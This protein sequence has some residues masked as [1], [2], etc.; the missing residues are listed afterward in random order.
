MQEKMFL[1]VDVKKYLPIAFLSYGASYLSDD[2]DIL[3]TNSYGMSIVLRQILDQYH[4]QF[5]F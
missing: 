5:W 3:R 1:T 2:S 4:T